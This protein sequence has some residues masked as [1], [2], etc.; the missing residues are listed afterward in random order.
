VRR[1]ILASLLI[2]GAVAAMLTTVTIAPFSDSETSTGN[3]VAAGT[4]DLK[5]NGQDDPN[6]GALCTV[7]PLAE[8]TTVWCG[9]IDVHNAGSLDGRADIHFVS[10]SCLPGEEPES[11]TPGVC[12]IQ[13]NLEVDVEYD[14][15]VDGECTYGGCEYACALCAAGNQYWCNWAQSHGCDCVGEPPP[16]DD[17]TMYLEPTPLD[18]VLSQNINLGELD[19]GETD[20]IC[21]SFHLTGLDNGDQGDVANMDI[22]FTL[23]EEAGD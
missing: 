8:S 16:P 9:P 17:E 3:T 7:G 15:E 21:I 11:E 18:D 10:A 23:H 4:L 22:E 19:A 6:V 12:D 20:E 2:V 5:V 13:H 1:S 14:E